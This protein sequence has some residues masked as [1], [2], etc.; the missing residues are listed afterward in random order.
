MPWVVTARMWLPHEGILL[1]VIRRCFISKTK[2]AL[3]GNHVR[4]SVRDLLSAT[5]LF[6]GFSWNAVWSNE[7]RENRLSD[8]YALLTGLNKF[9]SVTSTC[10]DRCRWNWL[11]TISAWRIQREFCQN[12]CNE[13]HS[14]LNI[15]Y[16]SLAVFYTSF[17]WRRYKWNCIYACTL[18]LH[19]I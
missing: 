9:L 13:I 12:L 6:V 2:N 10:F 14:F 5:K 1:F 8:G 7:L 18:K 15:V 17:F 11:Q 16:A 19:N 4:L 3:C